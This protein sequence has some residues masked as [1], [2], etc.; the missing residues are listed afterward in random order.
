MTSIVT[1]STQV[2]NHIKEFVDSL[3]PQSD[4][5]TLAE[6]DR[7]RHTLYQYPD[8]VE[9][10]IEDLKT[11]LP[12]EIPNEVKN[13]CNDKLQQWFIFQ[14]QYSRYFVEKVPNFEKIP[15]KEQVFLHSYFDG[16][17]AMFEFNGV[18]LINRVTPENTDKIQKILK[19]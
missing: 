12:D 1:P 9:K 14:P 6:R 2:P 16:I 7:I 8:V 11:P 17:L 15:S 18:S 3:K 4:A 19:V 5:V 13:Y 10:L